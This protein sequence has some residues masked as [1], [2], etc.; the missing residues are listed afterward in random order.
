M[1]ETLA[2][3]SEAVVGAKTYL[4]WE[5][6][7]FGEDVAGSTILTRDETGLIERVQVYRRLGRG[8]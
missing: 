1:Y 8:Y 4:E 3:T 7:I 5:A 6:R 2:F